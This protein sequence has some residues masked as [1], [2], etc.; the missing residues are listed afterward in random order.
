MNDYVSN[1]D[2]KIIKSSNTF[3]EKATLSE[4]DYLALLQG[5]VGSLHSE[6]HAIGRHLD[7]IEKN[8]KWLFLLNFLILAGV[9]C[10][11]FLTFQ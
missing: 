10:Q 9:C 7:K 5:K 8:S 6:I 3:V 4:R 1:A 11:I 2:K